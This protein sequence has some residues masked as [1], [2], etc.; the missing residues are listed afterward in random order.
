MCGAMAALCRCD[1]PA[2]HVPPHVCKDD[3]NCGGAWE[4]DIDG[5]DFRVVRLPLF[6]AVK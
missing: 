2:E 5:A 4:G 3:E 6:G 1:L